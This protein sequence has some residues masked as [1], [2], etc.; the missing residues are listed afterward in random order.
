LRN[1]K[2]SKKTLSWLL[3]GLFV[4][5][6]SLSV[7]YALSSLQAPLGVEA[8]SPNIGPGS[9]GVML[10]RRSRDLPEAG[11]SMLEGGG[12]LVGDASS[13]QLER[14]S[15]AARSE[16]NDLIDGQLEGDVVMVKEAAW[17]AMSTSNRVGI[18]SWFSQCM[19]ERGGVQIHGNRTGT[20][21]ATY[22]P[23]AGYHSS[24]ADR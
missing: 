15:E 17:W 23:R 20:L 4:G 13:I 21:L 22:D 10:N 12:Y 18:A 16:M 9:A 24:A 8:A 5:A 6:I 14:C 3:P 2:T 11:P 19:R 7:F 1:Q